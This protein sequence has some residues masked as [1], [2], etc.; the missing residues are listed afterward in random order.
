[1]KRFAIG[2]LCVVL[3]A[4]GTGVAVHL[5]TLD[6]L[7]GFIFGHLSDT[8][9]TVYAEG[10]SDRGFRHVHVGMS[11][12]DVQ[13]LIG[14]PFDVW[15]NDSTVCMR[16]SRSPGSHDYRIRTVQFQNGAVVDKCAEFHLD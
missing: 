7:F 13:E 16:W 8:E 9:D 2:V 11:L 4:V 10:Y 12:E 3:V 6:G 5:A 15:T 1:M 14:P